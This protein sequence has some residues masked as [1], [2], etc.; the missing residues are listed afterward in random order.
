MVNAHRQRWQVWT[1]IGMS[2]VGVTFGIWL[3]WADFPFIGS[4][5]LGVFL[6]WARQLAVGLVASRKISTDIAPP[7][8]SWLDRLLLWVICLLGMAVCAV[9][10]YVWRL[11]PEEWPAGLVFL[12]FGVLILAPATIREIQLRRK[13]IRQVQAQTPQ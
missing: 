1:L 11:W 6:W 5:W 3:C 4:L 8:S 12:L 7:L 9:G 13:A 2:L 10:V